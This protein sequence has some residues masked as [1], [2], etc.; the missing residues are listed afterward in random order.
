[1]IFKKKY[2]YFFVLCTT[3]IFSCSSKDHLTHLV[4]FSITN[5]ITVISGINVTVTLPTGTDVTALAPTI[6]I[7]ANATV[8][9]ASG[10]EHDFTKPVMYTVVSKDK[11]IR[12]NYIVMVIVT[13]ASDPLCA[14]TTHLSTTFESG[15]GTQSNPYIICTATQLNLIGAVDA[16]LSYPLLRKSYKL[17]TD[18]DLS[19]VTFNMIG[20][21]SQKGFS[22]SFD[23]NSKK[24]SNLSIN[25]TSSF[26]VGFISVLL[27]GGEIKN[28]KLEDITIVGDGY[29]GGLVGYSLE[30]SIITNSY[31][32]GT[33]SG[34]YYLGGLVGYNLGTIGNSYS[35]CS[36]TGT[37]ERT[38]GLVGDNYGPISNSC[39]T[40]AITGVLETGGLVGKN[41][42]MIYNS[43][44]TGAV[45]A[46]D[47]K[48][49]GLV[50]ISNYSISNSYATGAV[51][52]IN[53]VG[54]LVGE[55]VAFSV[56]SYS[57][58]SGAT[59]GTG[60]YVGGLI[61]YNSAYISN[62]YSTGSTEGADNVGGFAGY[63]NADGTIAYSYSIGAVTAPALTNVGGFVG[64]DAG[65]SF[66]ADFWDTE[67]STQA[68]SAG[69]E[70]GKVDADMKLQAT[71]QPGAADWDFADIWSLD[72]TKCGSYPETPSPYVYP[73]LRPKLW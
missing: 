54:G 60:Q 50:G 69:P 15:N 65:G 59:I 39:A 73:C 40:G 4:D 34:N 64:F 41:N 37:V 27:P 23:G 55:S 53:Y 44:S 29:L 51:E 30:T 49:G 18:I 13:E 11:K 19:G 21:F 35:T 63:Q 7:S 52:G 70:S 68:T 16:D 32:T 8:T 6:T 26:A 45:V 48:T 24:I 71:F 22:G 46:T 58:S 67:T 3:V 38:G 14:S 5:G 61:G 66:T 20:D 36:V 62:S 17:G 42:G 72:T 33:I 56:I 9:P 25:N 10:V 43:Y 47:D 57:Y 1:M 12:K 28:L 2:L 31:T